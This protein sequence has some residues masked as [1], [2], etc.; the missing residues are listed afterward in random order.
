MNIP[1]VAFKALNKENRYLCDG[2][3]CGDWGDEQLD[4]TVFTD[5]LF[6]IRSDHK[7]PSPSDVENHMRV[8]FFESGLRTLEQIKMLKTDY[9]AVDVELT[10]EE[11]AIVCE[12]NDWPT[13]HQSTE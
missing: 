4:T 10:P 1:A 11:F 12:R 3:D 2:I 6:I 9:E 8:F 7:R 13:G 5:A